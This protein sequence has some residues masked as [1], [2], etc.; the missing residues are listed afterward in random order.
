MTLS[1]VQSQE[2]ALTDNTAIA[3]MLADNP[4]M[5]PAQIAE[6]FGIS[7]LDVIKQLPKEQVHLLP[8]EQLDS[9]FEDLPSWGNVTTIITSSGSI[10]EVKGD[11]PKGKYG[12]GYYNLRSKGDGL[13]GHM[14]FDAITAIGLVSRPFMGQESHAIYLFGQKG[15]VIFKIYL[16]RDKK[17]VLNPEQVERF[18]ALKG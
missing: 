15:E 2:A 6:E 4:K 3:S 17:R 13:H 5:M 18:N 1:T 9:L 16:G 10:F 8:L 11:F 14:K 12:H 7:E